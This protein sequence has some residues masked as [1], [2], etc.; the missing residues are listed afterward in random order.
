MRFPQIER[1]SRKYA[2]RQYVA[3]THHDRKSPRRV[4][5]QTA[6]EHK[7][8]CEQI[9]RASAPFDGRSFRGLR[10]AW[11]AARRGRE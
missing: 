10:A 2:A 9:E 7:R 11:E 6:E 4:F 8:E 3:D 5:V 1:R